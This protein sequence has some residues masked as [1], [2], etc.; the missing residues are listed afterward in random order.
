MTEHLTDH[1]ALPSAPML[2][3]AAH[4]RQRMSSRREARARILCLVFVQNGLGRMPLMSSKP[5]FAAMYLV[6]HVVESVIRLS[7]E[8]HPG[9]GE[10]DEDFFDCRIR[11]IAIVGCN[12]QDSVKP[13]TKGQ[14]STSAQHFSR[15][16]ISFS[17]VVS[18]DGKFF[19]ADPNAEVWTVTNPELLQ[20]SH[21]HSLAAFR[22]E[23]NR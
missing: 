21:G 10:H 20:S 8:S 7:S 23:N 17:G 6:W 13:Y 5:V 9:E 16:A 1:E 11:G 14:E 22:T 4:D 18:D 15:K 3:C 12:T 2:G 19:V